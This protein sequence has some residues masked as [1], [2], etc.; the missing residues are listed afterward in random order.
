M[1]D[2]NL[3]SKTQILINGYDLNSSK[4]LKS[5]GFD[6]LNFPFRAI[7]RNNMDGA[8]FEGANCVNLVL[9]SNLSGGGSKSNFQNADQKRKS[10][11][12]RN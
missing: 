2:L 8:N 4:S 3:I 1:E 11:T 9:Y 5:E 12:F 7:H 10:S 6:Y